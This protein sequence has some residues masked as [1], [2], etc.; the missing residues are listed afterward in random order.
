[1]AVELTASG[2]L[3]TTRTR[4]VGVTIGHKSG[5]TV[6]LRNG[7][8]SGTILWSFTAGNGSGSL[9]VPLHGMLFPEGAYATLS[10]ASITAEVEG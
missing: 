8:A 7:G 2:D 1:M 4:I 9:Y 6:K 3:S 10:D 5:G